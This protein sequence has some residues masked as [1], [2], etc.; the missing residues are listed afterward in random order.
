MSPR[1]ASSNKE[2]GFSL[3]ELMVGLSLG[4]LTLLAMSQVYIAFTFQQRVS[5]GGMTAQT[6]AMHALYAIERDLQQAG[7]T[8]G[9]RRVLG[10]D[11][12]RDA[13]G[14]LTLAPARITAGASGAPD[15]LRLLWGDSRAAPTRL[16][17]TLASGASGVAF[18][19]TLGMHA[20]DLLALQQ[21]GR[22]CALLRLGSVDSVVRASRV[23]EDGTAPT[24]SRDAVD[25]GGYSGDAVAFN[26]GQLAQVSYSVNGTVLQRTR[27]GYDGATPVTQ[28]IADNIVSL[29]A[30]YGFDTRAGEHA[31]LEVDT[32][33]AAMLDADRSGTAGDRGDWQRM[34][35]LRLAVVA[36]SPYRAPAGA[37]GVCGATVAGAAN[38]PGWQLA[39]ADGVLASTGISLAHLPNWQCYRYRVYETV[40][41]LRNV[42]WGAP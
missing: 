17:A 7:L 40:A 36:R 26:L 30:Q 11:A 1:P 29:R 37:N 23:A 34:A 27:A 42:V 3:T 20:G 13:G 22:P 35:G 41:P 32:W 28:Q 31:R 38:A 24:A 10:C 18:G 25:A 9:E 8:F 39:Q 4:L 12:R 19:S 15:T 16:A 33:S 2:A 14:L 6:S 21:D 5:D